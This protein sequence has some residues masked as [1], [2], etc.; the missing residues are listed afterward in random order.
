MGRAPGARAGGV[1]NFSPLRA[2]LHTLSRHVFSIGPFSPCTMP[3]FPLF[4]RN[5]D[6][7]SL[8]DFSV[9]SLPFTQSGTLVK[10]LLAS[11]FSLSIL[12]HL[13]LSAF[14]WSFSHFYI[15][16]SLSPSALAGTAF[17]FDPRIPLTD[18]ACFGSEGGFTWPIG[19]PFVPLKSALQQ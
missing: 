17:S 8:R 14:P 18:L 10:F 13:H 3:V 2:S 12:P 16:S 1:E 6:S 15:P 11:T 4:R 19:S 7:R 5:R 9:G